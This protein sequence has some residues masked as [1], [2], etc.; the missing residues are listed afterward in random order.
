MD[1]LT[2][3]LTW[4]QLGHISKPCGILNIDGFYDGWL[5]W[6]ERAVE[7]GLVKAVFRGYLF[8]ETDAGRLIDAMAGFKPSPEAAKFRTKA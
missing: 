3:M 7:E 2:E 5:A 6:V 1:E 4:N 8:V